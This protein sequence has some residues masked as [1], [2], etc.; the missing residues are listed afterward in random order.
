MSKSISRL[1]ILFGFVLF[2]TLSSTRAAV[3]SDWEWSITPYA[4]AT[5][6][7]ADVSINDRQVADQT[8][9]ASDLFDAMDFTSQ[10]H[11]EGRRDRNG[12]LLDLFY[13]DLSDDDKRVALPAHLVGLRIEGGQPGTL[14]GLERLPA[15]EA[16]QPNLRLLSLCRGLP[17][18][19]G[20]YFGGR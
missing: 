20:S 5:D 8:I 7:K 1:T 6:V 15:F 3:A 11:I 12:L 10:L 13:V 19:A 18:R 17:L 14:P 4:W 2:T 9:D 16:Q